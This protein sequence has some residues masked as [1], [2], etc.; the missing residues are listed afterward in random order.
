V[1]ELGLLAADAGLGLG[2]HTAGRSAQ[3]GGSCTATL[4]TSTDGELSAVSMLLR[5]H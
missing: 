4:D 3:N 5:G 1:E 2:D